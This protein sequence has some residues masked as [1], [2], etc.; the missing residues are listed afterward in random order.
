MIYNNYEFQVPEEKMIR[1]IV[2]T[3][4]K[5]EADDDFA[6]VHALLSPKFN[7]VGY[8][9]AHFGTY[10]LLD[11]MQR[12]YDEL[13][14][15]AGLM[16][17]DRDVPI[18]KGCRDKLAN[19]EEGETSEGAE[20]IVSEAMKDSSEPL[21]AIFLGP[22][23][24]MAK[25]YQMEPRIAG[26]VKVIWIGG[27]AYPAGGEEFNLKNDI[28]AANVVFSSPLEVWQVPKNVYEMMPVSFSELLVRVGDK[29]EIG[30]YLCEQLFTHAMEEGPRKSDFRSG[31]TWVLGDS[32]A[33]GLLLY[34]DRFSFEYVQAPA[35]G[36]DMQYIHTKRNRPIRVYQKI[37]SRLILED[38]YAKL[39][40]FARGKM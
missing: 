15:V 22:L 27:G 23:T 33:V 12:S 11:S 8:V 29:G 39:A 5:N 1:L 16:G 25:A 35:I 9:A 34:E 19:L 30:A 14:K 37:D 7:Q 20:L 31:E 4:A 24:D 6:I 17:M 28:E 13:K 10:R 36:A 32:P 3:D 40:L 2:D 18:Y 38:M 21:Y 26:R